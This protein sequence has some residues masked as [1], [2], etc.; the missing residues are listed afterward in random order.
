MKVFNAEADGYYK[1]A[2]N[3]FTAN[4]DEKRI[5]VCLDGRYVSVILHKDKLYCLDST[6]YHTGGPLA[7][8]DIEDV[9]GDECIVCPWHKYQGEH[10][11]F[12]NFKPFLMKFLI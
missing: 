7:L 8:G 11:F 10:Q 1:V 6:C 9:D 12:Y 3:E 2:G 5:H 4:N